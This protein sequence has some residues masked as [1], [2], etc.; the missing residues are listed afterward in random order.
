A[1]WSFLY[2]AFVAAIYAVVGVHPLTVRLVQAVHR[3]LRAHRR[4]R[5]VR[6]RQHHG[7]GKVKWKGGD[8]LP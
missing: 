2:T 3:G 5:A 7:P 4:L 6:T 8:L 1:H